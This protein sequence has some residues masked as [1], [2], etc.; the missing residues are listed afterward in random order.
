MCHYES[1]VIREKTQIEERDG[2]A[3]TNC[4]VNCVLNKKLGGS[5]RQHLVQCLHWLCCSVY[6]YIV[7]IQILLAYF[8]NNIIR[9]ILAALSLYYEMINRTRKILDPLSHLPTTHHIAFNMQVKKLQS[10]SSYCRV[11]YPWHTRSSA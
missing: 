9:K 4:P 1:D 5:S 11:Q 10:C 7:S 6:D 8:H 2:N 3:F